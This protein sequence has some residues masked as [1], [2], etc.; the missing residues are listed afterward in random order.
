MKMNESKQIQS[1]F[2]AKFVR[3]QLVRESTI[4]YPAG[5]VMTCPHDIEFAA[6]AVL[7]S[8]DREAFL[9]IHLD[10]KHKINSIEV[11]AVGTLNATLVHPRECLKG[12]IL[13]NAAAICLVHNHPSGS[14]DPSPEDLA[15]T[16][17]LLAASEIIGIRV[18]DHLIL[19]FPSF[20]SLRETTSIWKEY[21]FHR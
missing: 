4:T 20:V 16:H 7:N 19:G 3:V 12:A 14:C 1:T 11:I 8:Y 15:L 18:I 5:E 13:G 21:P 6:R 2:R 17:Q 10:S 9:V